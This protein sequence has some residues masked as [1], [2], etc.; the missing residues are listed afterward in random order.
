MRTIGLLLLVACASCGS[1]FTSASDP[2]GNDSG[3]EGSTTNVPPTNGVEAGG[4]DSS[5]IMPTVEAGVAEAG[6]TAE[7]G[8]AEGSTMEAGVPMDSGPDAASLATCLNT[9]STQETTC[10]GVGPGSCEWDG[11]TPSDCQVSCKDT[12]NQCIMACV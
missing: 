2:Q 11:G 7:A 4:R 6:E 5:P 10:L 8:E 9:C 12:Y 3:S 1:A